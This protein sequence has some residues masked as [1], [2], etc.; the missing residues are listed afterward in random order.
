MKSSCN[1]IAGQN[2]EWLAALSESIFA[3]AMTLLLLELRVP[4]GLPNEARLRHRLAVREGEMRA[5][6][7]FPILY[8][9]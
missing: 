7:R 4:A 6:L 1:Q 9:C 3:V 2:K 8:K 5:S